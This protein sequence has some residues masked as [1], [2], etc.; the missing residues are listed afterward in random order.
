VVRG[1]SGEK[2]VDGV[3][4]TLVEVS[5]GLGRLV[6]VSDGIMGAVV[7][8]GKGSVVCGYVG[9]VVSGRGSGRIVVAGVEVVE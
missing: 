9:S 8:G 6:E 1:S 2:K 4:S 3:T 7:E 5:E